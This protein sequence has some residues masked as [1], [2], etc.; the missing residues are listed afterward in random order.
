V[1]FVSPASSSLSKHLRFHHS[2]CYVVELTS[3]FQLLIFMLN[4]TVKVNY[5]LEGN[6]RGLFEKV[7]HRISVNELKT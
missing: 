7:C 4:G 1:V 3:F 2:N 5:D 6:R